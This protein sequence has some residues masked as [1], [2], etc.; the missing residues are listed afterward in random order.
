M[1]LA[2]YDLSIFASALVQLSHSICKN[3]VYGDYWDSRQQLPPWHLLLIHSGKLTVFDSFT[4]Y[5]LLLLQWSVH[6]ALVKLSDCQ[7]RGDSSS[8]ISREE[9]GVFL[10]FCLPFT[11]FRSACVHLCW[12]L[13]RFYFCSKHDV[14]LPFLS[15]I[16]CTR[17][18]TQTVNLSLT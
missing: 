11:A 3:G 4:P 12:C 5:L 2:F 7:V 10:V 1:Q 14:K 13:Q 15:A 9:N 17:S 16:Q 8:V 6:S 18:V